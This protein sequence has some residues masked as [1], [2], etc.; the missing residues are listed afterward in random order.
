MP[1]SVNRTLCVGLGGTGRDVLMRVRR[2]IIDRYGSL[3]KFPI[4]SFLHIDTDVQGSQITDL[5]EGRR[6]RGVDISFRPSEQVP[7]TISQEEIELFIRNCRNRPTD[8]IGPYDHILRW[9]DPQLLHNGRGIEQGANGVRA[10]GRLAFFWNFEKVKTAVEQAKVRTQGHEAFMLQDYGLQVDQT[11]KIFVTGSLCGGTGSGMFLDMAYFLKDT[12]AGNTVIGHLIISPEL[13]SGNPS[14]HMQ[15]STYAALLELDYYSQAQTRFQV[16][17]SL[18]D[19]TQ[20][21]DTSNPPFDFLYLVSRSTRGN[22]F[23][24]QD[25]ATLCNI[26]AHAISLDFYSEIGVQSQANLDN[27][28]AQLAEE[29]QHPCGSCQQYLTFGLASIYYPH[30]RIYNIALKTLIRELLEFWRLGLKPL[31]PG[32]AIIQDLLDEFT[33]TSW[34]SD[35]QRALKEVPIE[36][37]RNTAQLLRSWQQQQVSLITN[38]KNRDDRR[39]MLA[40]LQRNFSNQFN[41][42]APSLNANN[43]GSWLQAISKNNKHLIESYKASLDRFLADLLNPNHGA[44]GLRTARNWLEAVMMYCDQEKQLLQEQQEQVKESPATQIDRD[45]Q[46]LQSRVEDLE[47]RLMGKAVA[48]REECQDTVQRVYKV[49]EDNLKVALIREI[50]QTLRELRSHSQQHF[51]RINEYLKQVEGIQGHLGKEIETIRNLSFEMT[52][53]AIFEEEDISRCFQALLPI[54]DREAEL[55]RLSLRLLDKI[56]TQCQSFYDVLQRPAG[57]DRESLYKD[58]YNHLPQEVIAAGQGTMEPVIKRF[59]RKYGS[60]SAT[61]LSQILQESQCLLPLTVDE[62]ANGDVSKQIRIVGFKDDNSS[63]AQEFR[64]HLEEVSIQGS[65]IVLIQA[66]DEILFMHQQAAFP[67]RL[68]HDLKAWESHYN[69][70]MNGDRNRGLTTDIR[71][72]TQF[73]P[74]IP[75]NLT[76]LEEIE[77]LFFSCIALNRL[78]ASESWKKSLKKIACRRDLYRDLVERHQ[79][80]KEEIQA[81]PQRWSQVY[82][83]QFDQFEQSVKDLQQGNVN[84]GYRRRL[85]D[86][87]E[88]MIIDLPGVLSR[89]RSLLAQ[90]LTPAFLSSVQPSGNPILPPIQPGSDPETGTIIDTTGKIIETEVVDLFTPNNNASLIN[91]NEQTRAER[92]RLLQDLSADLDDGVITE[93]EYRR[94]RERVLQQYPL[95]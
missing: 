26:I 69:L 29:D 58:I 73:D 42:V 64:R 95:S 67:L 19:I 49:S 4:V 25:K 78:T 72:R 15:A 28:K 21:V 34:G 7:V 38:C 22:Q 14:P 37:S 1:Q 46:A 48:I 43:R 70:I 8:R 88:G 32:Q 65:D 6:Y 18:R 35:L 23:S 41:K 63:D 45:Y 71:L 50:L 86:S 2:L 17:Y 31:E 10:I 5:G 9:F 85:L 52:G 81:Q 91:A 44:F 61:R 11:N 75:P 60:N 94:E 68:I 74:L 55:K 33:T 79:A 30:N 83:P 3:D 84:Y 20:T 12:Y 77:D 57:N 47:K 39:Q 62:F 27:V 87:Q 90:L 36:G 53:E 54:D 24:V 80:L 13:Y 59:L 92:R 82:E 40:Q 16:L 56:Q 93:E 89:V 51:D 66:E 76:T